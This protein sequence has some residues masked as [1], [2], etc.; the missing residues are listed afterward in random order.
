MG[1]GEGW[2]R[3]FRISDVEM[4]VA[5]VRDLLAGSS[6]GGW[7]GIARILVQLLAQGPLAVGGGQCWEQAGQ[8]TLVQGTRPISGLGPC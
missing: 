2:P 7:E 6:L 1:D 4:L 5:L 3:I 8:W